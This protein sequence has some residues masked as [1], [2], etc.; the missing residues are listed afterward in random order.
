MVVPDTLS[1]D[2]V[3]KPFR[4]RCFQ[5]MVSSDDSK[6]AESADAR[7]KLLIAGSDPDLSRIW[8][9][10]V[11]RYGSQSNYCAENEKFSVG[12]DG[13][14]RVRKHKGLPPVVARSM[15]KDVL[16]RLH[17]SGLIGYYRMQRKIKRLKKKYWLPTRIKDFILYLKKCVPCVVADD[18]R[19]GRQAHLKASHTK[20]R[21]AIVASVV[22][23]IL[24][25]RRMVAPK[26]YLL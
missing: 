16:N 17:G 26:L 7:N 5:P 13:V 4:Q 19:P 2:A 12:K 11:K 15:V 18:G 22:H 23:T 8:D 25:K 24:P 21:F 10:Q 3:H 20:R 14:I 1:R 9:E 6:S